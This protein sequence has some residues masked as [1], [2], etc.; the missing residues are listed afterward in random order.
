MILINEIAKIKVQLPYVLIKKKV[1]NDNQV[2]DKNDLYDD[3]LLIETLKKLLV[4]KEI[5]KKYF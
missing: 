4:K 1:K 5:K 3:Y 2:S